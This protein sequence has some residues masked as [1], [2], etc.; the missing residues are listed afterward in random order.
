MFDLIASPGELI[1]SQRDRPLLTA[2]YT[3]EL[4]AFVFFRAQEE[5]YTFFD[6][7]RYTVDDETIA[8]KLR[9]Y[10]HETLG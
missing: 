7:E 9:D 4:A 2:G 5:Q 3:L 8:T 6:P 1:D 10:H